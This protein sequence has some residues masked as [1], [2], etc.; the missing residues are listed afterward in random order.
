[1]LG[2]KDLAQRLTD[3]LAANDAAALE[4]ILHS[5]V[6]LRIWGSH[7]SEAYRPRSRAIDRLRSDWQAWPD[8][9]LEAF[10]VVAD[11]ER[12]AVEFRIQATEAGRYVEHNRSAFLTAEAGQIRSLDLYCSAPVPSARRKG[13]MAP[14]AMSDDEVRRLFDTN[15]FSGDIRDYV[16]PNG[17]GHQ[18]LSLGWG[19]SGDA[20]PGSNFVGETRW[21]E[22]EADARIDELVAYHRE[23]DIGFQWWV[24]PADTPADLPA[25]LERHGLALAGTI[26]QMARVGLDDVSDIPVNPRITVEALDGTDDAAIEAALQI[27]AA[28]FHLTPQQVEQQR[29]GWYE[30]IKD[31]KLRQ[32]GIT[33]LARLDGEPVAYGRI[34]LR[35]GACHLGGA[36]TR[37]EYRGQGV[38]ATLLRRRLEAARERGFNVAMIDAGPMSRRVVERRGFKAYGTVYVYGWMPAMDL[39]VIRSLVPND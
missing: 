36:A 25:R 29:S 7:G 8:P 9:Q 24:T 39:A 20:H 15:R 32:K 19:G 2:P 5:D 16:Y 1:M 26:A 31:P 33:Y 27:A 4:A 30:R 21:T 10:G 37:P 35:A 3:A 14:P 11:G 23:R 38:Y 34:N 17:G 6:S 18:G 28:S 22:Q 12:A 13:W